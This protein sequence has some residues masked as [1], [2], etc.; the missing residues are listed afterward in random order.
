[1]PYLQTW[2]DFSKGAERLYQ[3]NPWKVMLDSVLLGFKIF[4][5]LL[6]LQ[7]RFVVKYRHCNGSLVLKAT[8]DNVVS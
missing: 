1:M 6:C 7:I 5:H 8:D 3:Q 2:D 4:F